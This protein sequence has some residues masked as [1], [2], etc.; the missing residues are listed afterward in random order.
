MEVQ[1]T[2]IQFYNDTPVYSDNEHK[3]G[4]VWRVMGLDSETFAST[5]YD[6]RAIMWKAHGEGESLSIEKVKVLTTYS[7]EAL[8]IARIS[9]DVFATGSSNGQMTFY[10]QSGD[11][12]GEVREFKKKTTGF[13]SIAGLNE[14]IVATGACQRPKRLH[15]SNW[16]HVVKIW[17]INTKHFLCQLEGHT[18]GI[19]GLAALNEST[20]VSCSGDATL[21][22]W[23]VTAKT[24]R[25]VFHHEDYIY[26]LTKVDENK[27]VS[28]SRDRSIR[29]WDVSYEKEIGKLSTKEGIAH[30][31]TVYDVK[32]HDQNLLASGSRDGFVR[33]WDLRQEQCIQSLDSENGFVYGI[34]FLGDQKLI[35][36]TSGK[37][38]QSKNSK[39][40][41]NN[42]H[43][44]TW[45]IRTI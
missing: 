4:G 40:N 25:K 39:S 8:S 18:G 21:R 28:G 11:V 45:D 20:L 13:Y 1:R 15:E 36:G 14:N 3:I 26:G 43:V 44:L 10:S 16:Q 19:S 31:S 17:D 41:K 23:D 30:V 2:N 29:I 35:A 38:S 12:L 27:I 24:C 6:H 22:I 7:K 37:Q 33:L 9:D 34:D 42:A 32:C 5:S